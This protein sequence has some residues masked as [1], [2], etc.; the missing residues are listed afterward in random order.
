MIT[1]IKSPTLF[2]ARERLNDYEKGYE[3]KIL[4]NK[5]VLYV[6]NVIQ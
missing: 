6:I 4:K 2:L 1:F 5:E 3:I